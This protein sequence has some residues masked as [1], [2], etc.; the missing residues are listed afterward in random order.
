[1]KILHVIT[2]LKY[3]RCR[4]SARRLLPALRDRGDEVELLLFN[5][6]ETP[7]YRE[8]TDKG[9]TIHSLSTQNKP[10]D[11]HN[12]LGMRRYIKEFDIVHTHNTACQLFAPL[13]RLLCVGHRAQL[14]TTEHSASNRRRG[15]WYYWLVDKWMYG[16]YKAIICIADK[17]KHNL[18]EH[19][20]S[21]R[22]LL[23]INNGVDTS[24]FHNDIKDIT[25]Q[26]SFIITMTAGLRAE[27]DQDTVV[28][29]M[30]LLPENYTLRLVGSGARHDVL[31][32]LIDEVGVQDRVQMLG[33]RTDVPQLLAESDINLLSSHWEGL[34]L[35]SIEG[36]M[37]GRPFVASDVD[38]LREMVG[39]AGVLFEH[40]NA[41]ALADV[42]TSLCSDPAYYHDVAARCQARAA[43]YDISTMADEYHELYGALSAGGPHAENFAR[44]PAQTKI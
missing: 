12:V 20:K 22:G 44:R 1:M 32:A 40:G 2:S 42:I 36:M 25:G 26:Q 21:S 29:A 6:Q 10:Y 16:H 5:G 17:T 9:I 19:L 4:A 11:W 30:A 15:K 18:A 7:F 28:R 33:M 13:A 38:G 41:Q 39:G 34:S 35:S 27:K 3:G 43:Q 8:L 24:R 37:S 23:T 31:K 14:V